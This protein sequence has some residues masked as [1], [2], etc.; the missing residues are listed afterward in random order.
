MEF[1]SELDP[2]LF[3]YAQRRS[4]CEERMA[5]LARR[6]RERHDCLDVSHH[7]AFGDNSRSGQEIGKFNYL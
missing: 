6:G 3:I 4:K 2:S 5:Y 1:T 7:Q